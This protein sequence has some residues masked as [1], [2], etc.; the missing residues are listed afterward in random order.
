MSNQFNSIAKNY[1]ASFSETIIGKAQ[2]QIV[3]DYLDK[4]IGIKSLHILELNCGTGIDAIHLAEKGH[5]VLATD[6]S[7]EMLAVV[8]QKAN[9]FQLSTTQQVETMHWDLT[10]PFPA[11]NES[12]D[13]IFSDFGGLNCLSPAQLKNLSTQCSSLLNKNGKLILVVMGRF[14]YMETFYFLLKG[15]WR[16]AFRRRSKLP[17]NAKLDAQTT[18]PTWYYSPAQL[19]MI[20]NE[21]FKYSGKH[22]VGISIP[23]SYLEPFIKKHKKLRELLFWKDKQL[24]RFNFLAGIADHYLIE[25]KKA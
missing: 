18:I 23:P 7:E 25:F 22:P 5:H 4:H 24:R 21:Q 12:F 11:N 13:L 20:F 19:K 6:V 8:K 1:D 16:S 15:K 10:K 9:V 2:R 3:W 14:C 17:V